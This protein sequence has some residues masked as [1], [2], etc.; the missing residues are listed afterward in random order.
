M[1]RH[2]MQD[3]KEESVKKVQVKRAWEKEYKEAY[4]GEVT[5]DV[6]AI[7]DQHKARRQGILEFDNP[8]GIT[9]SGKSHGNI[10]RIAG[11]GRYKAGETIVTNE[12]DVKHINLNIAV[13]AKGSDVGMVSINSRQYPLLPGQGYIIKNDNIIKIK[14]DL[15]TEQQ[16]NNVYNL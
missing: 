7:I 10:M 14:R 6:Q 15:I 11:D 8:R 13:P 4:I 9:I 5:D 3:L 12:N 1:Y 2:G 16:A